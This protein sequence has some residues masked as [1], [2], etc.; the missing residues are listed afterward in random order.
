MVV[1]CDEVAGAIYIK[2]PR[3]EYAYTDVAKKYVE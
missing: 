3:K 2:S 1:D